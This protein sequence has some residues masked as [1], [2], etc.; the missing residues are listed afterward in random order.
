[1]TASESKQSALA[2]RP[3]P[4]TAVAAEADLSPE[5]SESSEH[6]QR[7]ALIAEAAF[8]IAQ[9]RGFAPGHELDDWLAAEREVDQGMSATEH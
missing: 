4:A 5:R 2:A 3:V 7:H 9:E 8:F 6:P 1:M